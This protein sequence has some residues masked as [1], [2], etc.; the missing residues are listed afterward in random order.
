[1]Y[2]P[3][4]MTFKRFDNIRLFLAVERLTPMWPID[5]ACGCVTPAK[6]MYCMSKNKQTNIHTTKLHTIP[7][8]GH[9]VILKILHYIAS[10]YTARQ[11]SVVTVC[12][13]RDW[14]HGFKTIKPTC[15]L[16]LLVKKSSYGSQLA[17]CK[18]INEKM[19]NLIKITGSLF[20]IR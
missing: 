3:Q 19:I 14:T 20:M 6:V 18:T 2:L 11:G 15:C 16:V 4:W 12:L 7:L 5:L 9:L 17:H 13:N 8:T 1:M 10:M